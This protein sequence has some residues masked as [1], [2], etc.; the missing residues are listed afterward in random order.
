MNEMN[1]PLHVTVRI[2]AE[3]NGFLPPRRRQRAFQVALRERDSVKDVIE[4]QG[5]PHTEVDLIVANGKAVDFT[6]RVA[7]GDRI[8]V[9]PVFR[10]LDLPHTVPLR[11]PAWEPGGAPRFILD[12]HLGTLATY[13]RLMGFDT[14]YR[15]DYHDG[16]LAHVSAE[17]GRILLTR[18]RGLLKRRQVVHGYYVWAT[19]PE[20]QAEEV[21]RRFGLVALIRPFIRCLQC[22]ALLE[23]VSKEAVLDRLE[24]LTRRYYDEFSRCSACSHIY[25]KGSHHERLQALVARL[26][27]D[28]PA[29]VVHSQGAASPEMKGT[30]EYQE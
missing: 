16:E 30:A 10:H 7:D 8:S 21:V 28:T 20:R 11:P 26:T 4:A 3:L 5:V 13:L 29:G 2:Y 23:T 17:E 14:R 25:W 24:P 19:N 12:Q 18:D 22:G 15:N 9:Y 6:Y 1:R 27:S